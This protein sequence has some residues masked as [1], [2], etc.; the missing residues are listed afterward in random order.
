M[1]RNRVKL[2]LEVG[3]ENRPSEIGLKTDPLSSELQ[4]FGIDEKKHLIARNGRLERELLLAETSQL[5]AGMNSELRIAGR[6][7]AR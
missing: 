5:A 2:E 4:G 3:A 1:I 7:A 6:Q